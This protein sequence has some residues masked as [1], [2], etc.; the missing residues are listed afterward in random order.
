MHRY[1]REEKKEEKKSHRTMPSIQMHRNVF[2]MSTIS[3]FNWNDFKIHSD[4]SDW[5]W[6]TEFSVKKKHNFNQKLTFGCRAATVDNFLWMFYLKKSLPTTFKDHR[7]WIGFKNTIWRFRSKS[8]IHAETV[9][10]L[11]ILIMYLPVPQFVSTSDSIHNFV[12]GR[13]RISDF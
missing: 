4:L 7:Y 5:K 2:Y 10:K 6:T 1:R 13:F 12:F 11:A 8:G 9:S 3:W